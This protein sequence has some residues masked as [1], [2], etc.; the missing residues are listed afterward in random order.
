MG[1]AAYLACTQATTRRNNNADGALSTAGNSQTGQ[2]PA[3]IYATAYPDHYIP[4]RNLSATHKHYTTGADL[5]STARSTC[6]TCRSLPTATDPSTVF[7]ETSPAPLTILAR[8]PYIPFDHTTT[9]GL[10]YSLT[11]HMTICPPTNAEPRVRSD[12]NLWPTDTGPRM[13]SDT[14]LGSTIT[15]LCV[16]IMTRKTAIIHGKNRLRRKSICGVAPQ[17]AC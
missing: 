5:C 16:T 14:A 11:R 9:V 13:R 17:S 7:R 10:P 2:R 15:N 4:I 12:A 3:M 1:S 6:R 8:P